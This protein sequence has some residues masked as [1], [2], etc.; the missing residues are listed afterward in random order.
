MR[1]AHAA[2]GRRPQQP[3]PTLEQ[4]LSRLD[5][6]GITPNQ[7]VLRE[8]F[9]VNFTPKDYE[10]APFHL[11]LWTLCGETARADHPNIAFCDKLLHMSDDIV[12]E[13]HSYVR[14]L[15]GLA[16]LCG[17]SARLSDHECVA[18]PGEDDAE[19]S[20]RLNGAPYCLDIDMSNDQIDQAAIRYLIALME[21]DETEVCR[22][23][24]PTSDWFYIALPKGRVAEFSAIT[25]MAF[26]PTR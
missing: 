10:A 13:P 25:Q 23:Q 22:V 26:L 2:A 24:T 8:D 5:A 3:A 14:I 15:L 1:H 6:F 4:Q 19:L 20:F 7:D 17:M 16:R 18:G 21:P 11:L 12:D 9:L